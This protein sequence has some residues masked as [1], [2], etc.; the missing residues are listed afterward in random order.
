MHTLYHKLFYLKLCS[1]MAYLQNIY[2]LQLKD[3]DLY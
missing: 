3:H 1:Q 2:N